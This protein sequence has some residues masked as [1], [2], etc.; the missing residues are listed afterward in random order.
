MSWDKFCKLGNVPEHYVNVHID[1]MDIPRKQGLKSFQTLANNFIKSPKNYIF[2][3]IPG[4]GKTHFTFSLIRG[5]LDFYPNV[6]CDIRFFKSTVLD[7]QLLAYTKQYGEASVFMNHLK[8]LD[9]LFIDDFGLESDTSRLFLQYNDLID[10]RLYNNKKTIIST[11]LKDE[12]IVKSFGDRV[13]SRLKEYSWIEF[14]GPDL[15]RGR[16]L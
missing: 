5:L 11:N 2:R 16:V 13:L 4:T 14:D 3:G 7:S 15:R 12:Q 10:S 8:E 6:L 1:K 9:F